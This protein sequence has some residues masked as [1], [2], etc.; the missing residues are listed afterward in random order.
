[1]RYH[2]TCATSR[3]ST[4]HSAVDRE[5]GTRHRRAAPAV[6]VTNAGRARA[7][8]PYNAPCDV[9]QGGSHIAAL[10]YERENSLSV[11][12]M[13]QRVISL[14]N[15]SN[16]PAVDLMN[17]MWHIPCFQK[18]PVTKKNLQQQR[19]LVRTDLP[20]LLTLRGKSNS[21]SK[22]NKGCTIQRH[23][24]HKVEIQISASLHFLKVWS[25]M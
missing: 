20:W 3:V 22:R 24:H 16:N 10:F 2:C 14:S 6:C 17:C 23:H 1:M 5:G 25:K 18:F 15:K 21:K 4:L 11:K 12:N 7:H 19:L 9:L 13:F 8:A